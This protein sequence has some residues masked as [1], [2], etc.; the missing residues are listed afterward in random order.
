[1]GNLKVRKEE[2]CSKKSKK[3]KWA[4]PSMKVESVRTEEYWGAVDASV[5]ESP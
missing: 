1:M 4:K 2:D 5:S 3:K